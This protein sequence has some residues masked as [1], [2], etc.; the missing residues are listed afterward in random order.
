VHVDVRPQTAKFQ[1]DSTEPSDANWANLE[2]LKV[3]QPGTT[4]DGE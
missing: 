2:K 3:L 1:H 4:D